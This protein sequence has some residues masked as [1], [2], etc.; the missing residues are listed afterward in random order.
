MIRKTLTILFFVSLLALSLFLGMGLWQLVS[1]WN[2]VQ[3]MPDFD[4]VQAKA[5]FFLYLVLFLSLLVVGVVGCWL[6]IH[7]R[8]RLIQSKR[9]PYFLLSGNIAMFAL[10]A[11]F[12]W[13]NADPAAAERA[14]GSRVLISIMAGLECFKRDVG[15]YPTPTEGLSAILAPPTTIVGKWN[16]PYVED[17]FRELRD[18]W[19]ELIEYRYP[20]KFNRSYYDLWSKGPNSIDEHETPDS[21][22][23][24]NWR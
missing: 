20:G 15:R 19:G 9:S 4:P 7:F 3:V 11:A 23:V 21:D 2:V 16:G 8:R 5:Q 22:D 1:Y 17:Q 12:I 6:L 14:R 24:K 10:I 13:V 18:P